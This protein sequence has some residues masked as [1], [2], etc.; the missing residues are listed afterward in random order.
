MWRR[1]SF[2]VAWQEAVEAGV[3]MWFLGCAVAED[4]LTVDKIRVLLG[5]ES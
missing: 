4:S 5:G 2:G 3:R 1:T